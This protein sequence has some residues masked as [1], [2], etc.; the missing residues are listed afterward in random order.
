MERARVSGTV[1][2]TGGPGFLGT[3]VILRLVQQTDMDIV[4]LVRAEDHGA[5]ALRLERCWHEWPDLAAQVGGR[6]RVMAS[7][8]T[9]PRLGLSKEEYG[10]LVGGVTHIIHSAADMRLDG[11]MEELRRTNVGGTKNMLE[12]AKAAHADHGITRY[13][14]VSTAYVAGG[15][16]GEV[17]EDNLS[18]QAK[19]YSRY[20]V[21]KFEGEQLV[22]EAKAQLPI[23]VFR[24]GMVVGDSETGAIK[25]FN[26]MYYPLK[27]Y[28]TGKLRWLPVK[29]SLKVN[30]IPVDY[31]AD[32]IVKLMFEPEAEG[33]NFHLTASYEDLPT[34]KEILTC[35]R[36]RAWEKYGIK[37]KKPI[38]FPMP[39]GATKGRYKAQQAITHERTGRF[40]GL[41]TIAPYFNERRRFRRDNV[42]RLLGRYKLNWRDIMPA[43]IDYAVYYTFF[44]K[45][46]RTVH[47]QILFRMGSRSLPVRIHDV[48]DGKVHT[49]DTKEVRAEIFA[50]A[51]ALRSMGVGPGDQ[52]AMVGLNSSRYVTLDVGIGLVGA[53]SVPLYY[54]SPA[55]EVDLLV[56]ASGSKV[57]LVGIPKLLQT[58]DKLES[59]CPVVSF[60]R[61][62]PPM[63]HDRP[64][65]RWK[66]FL[67]LGEGSTGPSTG[68][69][70]FGDLGTVRYTSGTTGTPKG[71]TF[72]HGQ[73]KWMGIGVASVLDWERRNNHVAYLSFLPM[74]HIVEGILAAYG[75]YFAPA[76]LDMYYLEDFRDLQKTLPT[77]RPTIFFSVPRFYEK[78]WEALLENNVGRSYV[79]A[80][81]GLK[82]GLL[83]KLVRGALLKK[84]GLDRCSQM[85]V[86]AAPIGE[87]LIGAYQDLGIEVYNA[88]G[89][90]E[91]PL[92]TMNYRGRNRPGTVGEPLP[93]TEVEIADD[94]EILIKG[95]QMTRG[96]LDP[97][98]EPPFRDGYFLTGDLGYLTDEGSLVIHGRK[99]ELIVTSYGKNIHPVKVESLLRDIPGVDEAMV[100]GDNRPYLTALVWAA[101][102]GVAENL[103]G[104]VETSMLL[105]NKKLSH[106]EQVKRWAVLE[107]DL[108]IDGGDLTA[109]LKLKKAAV[110]E[111]FAPLIDSLYGEGQAPTE[112]VLHIGGGKKGK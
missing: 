105:T 41:L 98:M 18:D 109:S 89:L 46:E 6:V 23:S 87:S 43:I 77:V 14:Q 54:T 22:A 91:A 13:G 92:V 101:K 70:G 75:P 21:S 35:V 28:L 86:G 97:S 26:T 10:E 82:K 53:A 72:D 85:F 40:E 47:E 33:L 67:A 66:D 88:F 74:N 9:E 32:A 111:R 42:D 79:E 12:L 55:P 93:E 112:G 68:P 38:L 45:T 51:A 16:A 96:Y 2:V 78:V 110:N 15:I 1:L 36:K 7:D 57:L 95:P 60:C 56:K 106:A 73:L 19:F 80:K 52:V 48:Y 11:P 29:P 107:N 108:T 103:V 27:L 58:L 63:E 34:A 4:A 8:I 5:A 39:T 76:K 44:H 25:N 104:T 102:E 65:M 17:S 62:D 71:V 59:E 3:Q 20:E 49:R 94:G 69:V 61:E 100:V 24:P 30:M 90:T 84:A 64:V 83:R 99:K 31:V 37:L 81:E 50:V